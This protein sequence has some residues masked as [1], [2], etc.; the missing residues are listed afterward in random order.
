M[1]MEQGEARLDK[2]TSWVVYAVI[3]TVLADHTGEFWALVG[4]SEI[5]PAELNVARPLYPIIGLLL[6]GGSLGKVMALYRKALRSYGIPWRSWWLTVLPV[7]PAAGETSSC[8]KGDLRCH[9]RMSTTRGSG[10]LVFY[11]YC[12]I[13]DKYNYIYLRC[14]M[15]CFYIPIHYEMIATIKLFNIPITSHRYFFFL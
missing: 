3:R 10:L 11:L 14:T 6:G 7:L 15:W 9:N 1:Q 5:S 12:S 4:P 8:F 2:G 13:N